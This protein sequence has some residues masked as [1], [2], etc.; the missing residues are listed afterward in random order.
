MTYNEQRILNAFAAQGYDTSKLTV[1][2]DTIGGIA[3]WWCE[4]IWTTRGCIWGTH[5]GRS[6]YKALENIKTG[7]VKPPIKR[8]TS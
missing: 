3:A 5:L 8:S 4:N 7:E 1:Y 6:I 2:Y